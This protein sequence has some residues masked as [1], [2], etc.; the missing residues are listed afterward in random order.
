M[1]SRMD[2]YK[3]EEEKISRHEKNSRLY[4]RVDLNSAPERPVDIANVNWFRL[5][6][7][8]NLNKR[9]NYQRVKDYGM[10]EEKEESKEEKR[11]EDL[12]NLY[13][14]TGKKIYDINSILEEARKERE[15][16]KK[17]KVNLDIFSL[18]K[19]EIEAYKKDKANRTKKDPE[20][21]K[22]LINTITSRTLSGELDQK[23]S[24]DLLSD[25]MATDNDDKVKNYTA[26]LDSEK[27]KEVNKKL[28]NYEEPQSKEVKNID[29]SFYTKSMD[30]SDK[31]FD[32][33]DEFLETKK[34]P[35]ILKI[36]LVLL[37]LAL[38]GVL[39]YFLVKSF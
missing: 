23:T 7:N 6:D 36:L 28:E 34:M 16:D 39:V 11:L 25:L 24:V 8:I 15:E 38:V 4:S 3:D 35:N 17:D 21:M 29:A 37:L 2:R 19:E 13:K 30:L 31:D 10:F 9:E 1:A 5:E 14:S 18:T 26:I 33:D 20:K 12:N 22:E 27:I 32:L